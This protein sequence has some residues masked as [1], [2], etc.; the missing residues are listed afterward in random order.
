MADFNGNKRSLQALVVKYENGIQIYS[1]FYNGM[2]EFVFDDTTYGAIT[3]EQL[4]V[5]SDNDYNSRLTDFESFILLTEEGLNPTTDLVAGTEPIIY[6]VTSCPLPENFFQI[7]TVVTTEEEALGTVIGGGTYIRNSV[8]TIR[9]YPA[10]NCQFDG[11]NMDDGEHEV[12]VI[13]DLIYTFTV[14]QNITFTAMFSEIITTTFGLSF[15][16]HVCQQV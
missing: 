5:L 13:T 15:T 8:C 2:N 4:R 9:A 3:T 7:D 1:H 11:W 6:D 16:N 14:T 10:P 12:T